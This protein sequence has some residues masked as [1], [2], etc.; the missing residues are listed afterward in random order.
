MVES[1][2]LFSAILN[3][4]RLDGIMFPITSQPS[5]STANLLIFKPKKQQPINKSN[6][7]HNIQ[8]TKYS[9]IEKCSSN[10]TM[11]R[12]EKRQ[13]KRYTEQT[14]YDHK[15]NKHKR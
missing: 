13:E 9:T 2:Y 3:G 1:I 4:M 11:V 14:F 8:S 12:D 5:S 15:A 10:K 6:V 7:I